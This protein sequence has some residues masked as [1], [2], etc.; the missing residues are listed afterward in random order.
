VTPSMLS[1]YVVVSW[2][3]GRVWCGRDAVFLNLKWSRWPSL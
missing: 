1:E 2:A 3:V